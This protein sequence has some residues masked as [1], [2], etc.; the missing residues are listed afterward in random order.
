MYV[1]LSNH[2]V[3]EFYTRMT[4]VHVCTNLKPVMGNV[5][6]FYLCEDIQQF[7]W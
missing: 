2:N 1:W 7:F 4:V 6:S 5:C 3:A